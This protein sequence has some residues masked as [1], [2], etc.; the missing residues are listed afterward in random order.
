MTAIDELLKKNTR[1]R[2]IPGNFVKKLKSVQRNQWKILDSIIK[3]MELKGTSISPIRANLLLIDK[4]KESLYEDLLKGEYKD[5]VKEFAAEFKKQV[6]YNDN[7]YTKIS[8]NYNGLLGE[9]VVNRIQKVT[10]TNLVE[11]TIKTNFLNPIE[12]TLTS[13][14]ASGAGFNET[15]SMLNDFI[16]GNEDEAGGIQRWA[17]QLAHDSFANSDR[18]YGNAVSDELGLEFYLYAGD[19]IQTTRCFCLERYGKYFHWKEIAAWGRG[20]DVGSCGYPWAGMNRD[21]TED[22]IFNYAGGYGCLH[23]ISGVSIFDV[24][25]DVVRRNVDNGNYEPSEFEKQE[26]EL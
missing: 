24:P 3:D 26:F 7:Y 2:T 11:D 13:A 17:K 8:D 19:E 4:I 16:E 15:L 9:D 5:A 21:T 1:L 20:D 10:V 22:T 23:S 12:G 14:V 18:A 6:D 25:E